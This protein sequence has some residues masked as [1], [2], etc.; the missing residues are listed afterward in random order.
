MIKKIIS[1]IFFRGIIAGLNF[2]LAILTTQYLGPKGKGDVSLFALNLTIVQLVSNFIGGPFLVYLVPRKNSMQLLLIS[3]VW[4]VIIS[5]IVPVILL[6]FSLLEKENFLQLVIISIIFSFVSINTQIMTGKEEI[7]KYNFTSLIQVLVL[8]AAFLF[9]IEF[10][11]MKNLSSYIHALYFSTATAFVVSLFFILKYFEKI[12]LQNIL[13]TFSEA[14]KKGFVLQSSAIAHMFNARLSFYF[15]DHFHSGGREEVGIY[16][17]AVSIAE[18]VWLIAQSVSLVLYSRIVNL[19]DI[20][21]SRQLTVALIKIVFVCT[22]IFTFIL[23]VLPS[24]L[25]AFVFGSGFEEVKII[26]FPL[27]AGIIILSAGIILSSYFVGVGNPKICVIA[28][29]IGLIVTVVLGIILIPKYGMTGAGI[30]ASI[31]YSVSV[32]YQLW[33]FISE[34]K[35]SRL[36]DF[37][38]TKKDIELVSVELKNIFSSGQ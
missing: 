36:N 27:S 30:T 11:G 13:E 8:I 10:Y 1:T 37:L 29:F 35:E 32:V 18:A 38:F 7:N 5:F 20:V 22:I 21:K 23:L 34:T 9:Y 19:S 25:F 31:S 28:S 15:L 17:V 2:F 12:S 26:L 14:I 3:Y 24:S 6:N 33:K 4:A 16:S